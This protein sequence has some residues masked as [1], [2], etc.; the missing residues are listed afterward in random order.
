MTTDDLAARLMALINSKPSSPRK[1][2]IL[3]V[4]AEAAPS[5]AQPSLSYLVCPVPPQTG[6]PSVVRV[7]R[8]GI[9]TAEGWAVSPHL[10]AEHTLVAIVDWLRD[11]AIGQSVRM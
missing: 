6:L 7:E 4:L 9:L 2:E 11:R 3:A 10:K 5:I 1:E 8:G